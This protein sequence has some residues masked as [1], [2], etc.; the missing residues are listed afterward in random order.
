MLIIKKTRPMTCG[1][2]VVAVDGS[3]YSF[4]GLM[5]GLTL[6]KAFSTCRAVEAISAF[7]PYFHYAAFHSISGVL[8]G[9]PAKCSASRSRKSYTKKSSTVASR[10][11]HESHLDNCP[12]E[13]LR[14]SKP[15]I[16]MTPSMGRPSKRSFNTCASVDIP[17]LLIVESNSGC[18]DDEG[19]SHR[20]QQDSC[21]PA[22]GTNPRVFEPEMDAPPIDTLAEYTIAWTEE[23]LRPDGKDPRICQRRR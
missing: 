17:A 18:R 23:A 15:D 8:T 22:P 12:R 21:G 5:T 6:G 16:T 13:S 1:K 7:D 11:S 3:P 9:K 19:Y 20:Q 14:P 2:I 10:R 4:V